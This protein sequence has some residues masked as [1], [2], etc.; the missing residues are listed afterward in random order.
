MELSHA[1]AQ[2]ADIRHQI[3]RTRHY[4]GF[5]AVTTWCTAAMALVAAMWQAVEFPTAANHPIE[6]VLLWV[7]IA[8]GCIGMTAVEIIRRYRNSDSP[9]QQE[10]TPLAVEQ[11]LPF[12]FVGGLLTWVLCQFAVGSVW[13]LPGLW[14]IFFGLGLLSSRRLFPTPT[15]FVGAFYV[16][17]GLFN[18]DGNL[19]HFSPWAMAIPFGLGQCA[20][21]FIL[22]WCLER[23]HAA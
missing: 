3:S 19:S 2:I 14:Q 15:L 4:R 13:M 16:A 5:R 23:R 6:F 21:A 22:Y 1:L 7:G 20:N 9:L 11:F 12:I 8:I 10:L 17:C 18:L